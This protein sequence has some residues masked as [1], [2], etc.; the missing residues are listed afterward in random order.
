MNQGAK[1]SYQTRPT[2]LRISRL[3]DRS[4]ECIRN[5]I[6]R[7]ELGHSLAGTSSDDGFAGHILKTVQ[8]RCGRTRAQS[9]AVV[10]AAARFRGLLTPV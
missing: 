6:L 1:F 3:L 5:Y 7:T 9:E 4:C 10:V 2:V 8:A